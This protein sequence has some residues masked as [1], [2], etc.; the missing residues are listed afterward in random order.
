MRDTI[1]A[2]RVCCVNSYFKSPEWLALTSEE[3]LERLASTH[4]P[5]HFVAAREEVNRYQVRQHVL[6]L[7]ENTNTATTHH[8]PLSLPHPLCRPR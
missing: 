6:P 3:R 2:K 7:A 5:P 1:S 4:T 8:P